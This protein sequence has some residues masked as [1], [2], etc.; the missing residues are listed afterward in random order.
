[1]FRIHFN[2]TGI[3]FAIYAAS[4]PSL[5]FLLLI[6]FPLFP[7]ILLYTSL[8]LSVSLPSYVPY[9]PTAMPPLMLLLIGRCIPLFTLLTFLHLS[10]YSLLFVPRRNPNPLFSGLFFLVLVLLLLRAVVCKIRV[11]LKQQDAASRKNK[12]RRVGRG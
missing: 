7:P 4:S 11:G 12:R 9:L 6:V 1:M 5:S 10:S 8:L 2:N 3:G